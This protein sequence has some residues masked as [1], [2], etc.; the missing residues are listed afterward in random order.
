MPA[1]RMLLLFGVGDGSLYGH[2][3]FGATLP[4]LHPAQ[5]FFLGADRLC[6]RELPPGV[7]LL[8]GT[9]WNSPEGN[10]SLEAGANFGVGGF[11]HAASQGI[12]EKVAFVG[13]GLA[14]EAAVAG[15]GDSLRATLLPSLRIALATTLPGCAL[16]ASDHNFIGLVAEL[17]GELPMRG[18]HLGG[19]V[20]LLF[21]TGGVRGDLR[22]LLSVEAGFSRCS[23]ICW[24]RGLEASRYSCE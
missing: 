16:R 5:D 12:A 4:L 17:G 9:S 24:L 22:G 11:T 7:V 15:K 23:R 13:D 19:R 3:L 20:N 1:L 2:D 21:V 10:A 8:S 14:L 6:R 18:Q